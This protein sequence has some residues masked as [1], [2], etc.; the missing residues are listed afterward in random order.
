MILV[1]SQINSY[2]NPWSDCRRKHLHWII[3][4]IF[5]RYF[6]QLKWKS[7][8]NNVNQSCFEFSQIEKTKTNLKR[9]RSHCQYIQLLKQKHAFSG[10]FKASHS[11]LRQERLYDRNSIIAFQNF[12][13]LVNYL[14]RCSNWSELFKWIVGHQ[15][16][17]LFLSIGRNANSPQILVRIEFIKSNSPWK[18]T[19]LPLMHEKK[20]IPSWKMEIYSW[21]E[22]I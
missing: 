6:S 4:E 2:L 14:F 3:S 17:Q 11:L 20:K 7:Y 18:T 12:T 10:A 19:F 13:A 21:N 8:Q 9:Q 22:N 5:F 15:L 16:Y 1:G